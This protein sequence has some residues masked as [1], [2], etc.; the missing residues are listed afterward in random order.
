MFVHMFTIM[1]SD[2][3]FDGMNGIPSA[4]QQNSSNKQ[5]PNSK[6]FV[7]SCCSLE[8]VVL[9]DNNISELPMML[10]RLTKLHTLW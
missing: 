3:G 2:S 6:T 1:K 8:V 5:V 10:R 9:A 4:Q 7:L